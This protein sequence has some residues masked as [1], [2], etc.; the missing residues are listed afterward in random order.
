M[1]WI[2][3]QY[4]LKCKAIPLWLKTVNCLREGQNELKNRCNFMLNLKP[5]SY[6]VLAVWSFTGSRYLYIILNPIW[7]ALGFFQ[8]FSR[9]I[10][11]QNCCDEEMIIDKLLSGHLYTNRKKR[12]ELDSRSKERTK[13]EFY[14]I[15]GRKKPIDVSYVRCRNPKCNILDSWLI[16]WRCVSKH[17]KI[18]L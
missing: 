17:L 4:I 18:Q 13:D 2:K 7:M 10:D 5:Y 14:S 12:G 16:N 3:L 15:Y 6:T 1:K 8:N 11:D 9:S